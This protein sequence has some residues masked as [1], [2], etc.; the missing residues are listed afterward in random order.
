M[1]I[2]CSRVTVVYPK[3]KRR[4]KIVFFIGISGHQQTPYHLSST[5]KKNCQEIILSHKLR[6]QEGLAKKKSESAYFCVLRNKTKIPFVY[7]SIRRYQD[8]YPSARNYN[9]LY[10]LS[11]FVRAKTSQTTQRYMTISTS[12]SKVP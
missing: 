12:A 6:P 3:N 10:S 8:R 1:N 4:Q 11:Y 2:V 9:N 7:K 5:S